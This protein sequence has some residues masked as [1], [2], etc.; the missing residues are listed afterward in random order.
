MR[1]IL[2]VINATRVVV[3]MRYLPRVVGAERWHLEV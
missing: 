2:M 3:V 1:C